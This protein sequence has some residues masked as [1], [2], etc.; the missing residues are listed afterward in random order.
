MLGLRKVK[1]V[2]SPPHSITFYL[3][4]FTKLIFSLPIKIDEEYESDLRNLMEENVNRAVE[5]K[6]HKQQQI[7]QTKKIYEKNQNKKKAC[8]RS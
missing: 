7:Y 3:I 4:V 8:F 1:S 5:H 6:N 2:P